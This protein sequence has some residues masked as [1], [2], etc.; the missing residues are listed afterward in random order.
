MLSREV[1]IKCHGGKVNPGVLTDYEILCPSKHSKRSM[2]DNW[3][4]FVRRNAPPPEF[5]PYKFEHAIAAGIKN[6]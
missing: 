3:N 6:E 4:G 5:C 1:C 2:V